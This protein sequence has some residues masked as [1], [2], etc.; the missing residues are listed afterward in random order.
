MP[1]FFAV[2]TYEVN[3]SPYS[4]TMGDFNGDNKLDLVVGA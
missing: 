2:R 4:V 1:R 3:P